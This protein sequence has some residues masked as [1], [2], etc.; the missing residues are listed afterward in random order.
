M[1]LDMYLYLK[2][3]D[4]TF[5]ECNYPEELK[6][7]EQ[8]I[9]QR[10]YKEIESVSFYQVG[11]WRKAN[12][13]HNWIVQNCAD[14]VDECQYVY[15]SEEKLQELLEKCEEVIKDN[16]KASELLPTTKG[17]FFGSQ[18]YDEWYFEDIK[19]TIHIVKK[20]LD[21]IKFDKRY[22]VIYQASW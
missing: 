11:Y 15:L 20:L 1:G 19:Y 3:Y 6:E 21:F 10:N 12:A 4:S 5:R 7:F 9:E 2:K 13:I 18:A 8:E 17:F 14:G 22:E 16:S